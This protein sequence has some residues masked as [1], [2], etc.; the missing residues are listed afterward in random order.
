M[1]G[2]GQLPVPEF[3]QGVISREA[4]EWSPERIGPDPARVL[5]GC[6]GGQASGLGPSSQ[7]LEAREVGLAGRPWGEVTSRRSQTRSAETHPGRS[8]RFADLDDVASDHRSSRSAYERTDDDESH[9]DCNEERNDAKGQ[10]L[11]VPSPEQLSPIDE[12]AARE[13]PGVGGPSAR[14]TAQERDH[15]EESRP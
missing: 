9:Q 5:G 11:L 12:R 13:V 7:E 15:E 1:L 4:A 10:T 8:L 14:E 2:Q 6:L 3:G